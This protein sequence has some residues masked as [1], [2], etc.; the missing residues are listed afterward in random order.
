MIE[1][2]P[3]KI[4]LALVVGPLRPDGKHELVTLFER[5]DLVDD[6]QLEPAVELAVTGFP[7]DTIVA[8]AITAAAEAAGIEPRFHAVLTKR[9]PVAAGLGGG[10]SDAAAALRA[11]NRFL[12]KPLGREVL[13][14]IATR[15][16][17]DVPFFLTDGPQLGSGD[18]SDLAPVAVPRNYTA[19]LWLPSGERKS[20]TREIYA[21]F[22]WRE[23]ANGFDERRSEL[24]AAVGRL[25]SVRD[26]ARLPPNDLARSTRVARLLALGAFR[27]DV[28][29]AGPVLYGLF[30]EPGDAEKAAGRLATEG[31]TWVCR[32]FGGRGAGDTA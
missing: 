22:D 13:H 18:G 31:Q 26:L 11:V 29:G 17:A 24:F 19:V 4:N 12:P 28:S 14:R 16:G 23:G 21:R 10:S 15:L 5:L 6:V 3:A 1:P 8:A 20:S 7:E 27:A 32:P 2:A 25:R 30:E 9:I